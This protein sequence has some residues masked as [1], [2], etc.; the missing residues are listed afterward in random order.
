MVLSL[1]SVQQ[2]LAALC[3]PYP[4]FI[5]FS[6]LVPIL[7]HNHFHSH[8]LIATT[9]SDNNTPNLFP[10]GTPIAA[11]FSCSPPST[12]AR[13]CP[14]VVQ[15]PDLFLPALCGLIL[16]SSLA[17]L[18][19][20]ARGGTVA[21]LLP[22]EWVNCPKIPLWPVHCSAWSSDRFLGQSRPFACFFPE[23]S[24]I[25]NPHPVV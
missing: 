13:L 23:S 17:T 20:T 11:A 21:W 8:S 22:K 6:V 1:L 2:V 24:F 25:L 10:V 4:F 19:G 15:L 14:V 3:L 7:P 16:Q 5:V 9:G 18:T 12:S